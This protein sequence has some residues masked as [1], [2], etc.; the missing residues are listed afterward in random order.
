MVLVEVAGVIV[1]DLEASDVASMRL[2][3]LDGWRVWRRDRRNGPA[4]QSVGA[5]VQVEVQHTFVDREN[6]ARLIAVDV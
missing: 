4:R 2:R 6:L 1:D 3:E 5:L